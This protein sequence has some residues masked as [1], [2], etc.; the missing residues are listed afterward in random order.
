[1]KQQYKKISCQ[2]LSISE[3][4]YYKDIAKESPPLIY[5]F[6]QYFSPIYI[7]EQIYKIKSS[8]KYLKN[9]K[10]L[11]TSIKK[12]I[13]YEQQWS[14]NEKIIP[15]NNELNLTV[16][17]HETELDVYNR[18]KKIYDHEEN[19]QNKEIETSIDLKNEENPMLKKLEK[20]F[21]DTL[22]ILEYSKLT[23]EQQDD[24]FNKILDILKQFEIS[25]K[26]SILESIK[27]TK[28]EDNTG[29]STHN[30]KIESIKTKYFKH[31]EDLKSNE[32]TL[33][34]KTRK[35]EKMTTLYKQLSEEVNSSEEAKHILGYEKCALLPIVKKEERQKQK[36]IDESTYVMD[37]FHSENFLYM[38]EKIKEDFTRLSNSYKA[39]LNTYKIDDA[40]D[41]IWKLTFDQWAEEL[42]YIPYCEEEYHIYPREFYLFEIKGNLQI[43]HRYLLRYYHFIRNEC[44]NI[45]L[46]IHNRA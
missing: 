7:S 29:S 28:Q 24:M 32:L 14:D 25:C 2:L 16:K 9:Y 1:M 4:K 34:Q 20:D 12:N 15:L 23:P 36:M 44:F 13:E 6:L 26:T 19:D 21:F 33:K 5:D 42:G 39:F 38:R 11:D 8:L 45:L 41:Q 43:E 17:E 3:S 18:M 37:Q 46:K 30:E 40:F 31:Y 22:F 10:N 35:K 27:T